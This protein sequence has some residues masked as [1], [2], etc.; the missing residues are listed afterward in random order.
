MVTPLAPPLPQWAGGNLF[1]AVLLRRVAPGNTHWSG[2][3]PSYGV[4]DH[5]HRTKRTICS[6]S[7][8]QYEIIEP[9]IS[10]KESP[11]RFRN[12]TLGGGFPF[13]LHRPNRVPLLRTIR[14]ETIP[15]SPILLI[16]LA[17]SFQ[18]L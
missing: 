10:P 4:K 11:R 8:L 15:T 3:K 14:W 6:D 18:I 5:T 13:S 2:A 9:F 1:W 16:S 7:I 17:I 12:H